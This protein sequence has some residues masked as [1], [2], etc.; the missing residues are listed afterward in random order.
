MKQT[1]LLDITT[2]AIIALLTYIPATRTININDR[3]I[4]EHC[5]PGE[6]VIYRNETESNIVLR[7]DKNN[8]FIGAAN[9][10]NAQMNSILSSYVSLAIDRSG[11]S[12]SNSHEPLISR[13]SNNMYGW[14]THFASNS[15]IILHTDAAIEIIDSIHVAPVTAYIGARIHLENSFISTKELHLKPS[16][17]DSII[18]SIVFFF[19]EQAT[20]PPFV[21]GHID[22]YTGTTAN[23]IV[24][25]GAREVHILF[26]PEA[27]NQIEPRELASSYGTHMACLVA[28][29]VHTDGP[30]LEMGAGDY[31]T[32]LLHS[33]CSKNERYLLSTD[34]DQKWL[35]YFT[36]MENDWH[37][38]KYV[39][40]YEDDW[41]IN[42]QPNEWDAIGGDR[43]WSVVFIDHRPGERRVIDIA[44]L[45]NNT[46]IFVVHDTEQSEYYYEPLL[47][48][49]R[50]KYVDKRYTTQTTVV[51]DTIDVRKFF[52]TDTSH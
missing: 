22:F 2:Y 8:V 43:H 42:P 15:A 38:F 48:S 16:T 29:A 40:V 5:K 17:S 3:N 20:V 26:K 7:I 14:K 34:T 44:R 36:D 37:K 1:R 51:S 11:Y 30:I 33:V 12:E 18:A 39:K 9:I 21:Q 32:P 10:S 13:T 49:F 35:S 23:D 28:A 25:C 41:E 19:D 24:A 45:R 50:Y 46:E 47:S 6:T 52:K 31:S 27:F 4:N